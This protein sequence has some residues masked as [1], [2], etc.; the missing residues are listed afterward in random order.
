MF[1]PENAPSAEFPYRV[2]KQ[3]GVGSMG[4]VFRAL[5][6][7]LE[8]TVA[9]KV[10]RQSVLDEE[11]P[12]VRQ[13][14]RNRFLQ[15]ARAAA[16][17]SHPG[18][19]TVY[20]VGEA[21]GLPYL[22]MEW[23]DGRSLDRVLEERPR[24][25]IAETARLGVAL[26]DTLEA[27]HRGGVV[28]RDIKPSNLVLL[29]DGRLKVTDFGIALV[30]GRELVKTQAGV[31]LATPKFAS[32]EQLR[33][34]EV[35]GRADLFSA[36]ILLYRLLTGSFPFDGANFMELASTILQHEP[37]APR[38]LRPDI[39]PAIEAVIR[40]ALRKSR[41]QRFASAA[42]M[43]EELRPFAGG[44]GAGRP[45]PGSSSISGFAFDA[46]EDTE[47][48]AS[49]APAHHRLPADPRL[50]LVAIAASWPGRAL[51][52]QP[53]PELLGRLLERPLHAA[54]FAGAVAIDGVY[55]FIADGMLLGAVD[56][57]RGESGDA[58][59]EALAPESTPRLHPLPEGFPAGTVGLLT[60]VLN[61]PRPRHAD[62][63]SSFINL[64]ALA[65]KL[66]HHRVDGEP[67]LD[68]SGPRR[69]APGPLH[70]AA[71]DGRE[72]HVAI[73]LR[74]RPRGGD[75]GGATA[76]SRHPGADRGPGAEAAVGGRRGGGAITPGSGLLPHPGPRPPR[77]AAGTR[78]SHRPSGQS[79]GA[80]LRRPRGGRRA[81]PRPGDGGLGDCC[82]TQTAATPT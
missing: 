44:D 67:E 73:A 74:V 49:R 8:R 39:P 10:L 22:V 80:G 59:A 18:V 55:L 36:G 33:G 26:L 43:A 7:A 66:R 52:R 60:T 72:L 81:L 24:F 6:V 19:T 68:R 47:I 70:G 1:P 32:P 79:S 40:R 27:A 15:E 45:D 38:E 46:G 61:P 3:I 71:L 35:D 25:A 42:E 64:P 57:E 23:L 41:E 17:L 2:E 34:I 48:E 50:A 76:G 54:P 21:G 5:K 65:K 14:L 69:A 31:V 29:K 30:K 82:D 58:V 16:A 51:D 4:I 78:A 62:L 11:T 28:H 9:I 56:A 13:E 53:T 12:E 20:R 63:D 37:I 75:R 77:T